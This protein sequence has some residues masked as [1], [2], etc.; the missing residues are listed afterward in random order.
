MRTVPAIVGAAAAGWV[1][2]WAP[3]AHAQDTFFQVPDGVVPAQGE[4]FTQG[5][6][7]IF[8]KVD[9]AAQGVLGLGRGF[10]I[11]LS[12]YNFDFERTKR[13]VRLDRQADLGEDPL[14]PIGLITAQ[15]RFAIA[16]QFEVS[17]G[18]QTGTQIP[19]RTRHL[20]TREYVNAIVPFSK[21]TRCV[22]GGYH[23]NGAFH[24]GPRRFGIWAGCD[25]EIVG[26]RLA[27]EVDFISGTHA[28][29]ATTVGP[30]IMFT[31]DVSVT[32]GV[33]IPNPESEARWAGVAQI[34]IDN[35]LGFF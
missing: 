23:G 28:F 34:E 13:G 24:G 35:F 9:V 15:K 12:L 21:N 6:T 17:F 33:Q 5:Q 29:A 10:E 31:E 14:G 7:S 2:S 11:G 8:S 20:V 26:D 1:A 3:P 18:A 16:K 22:L 25:L 19:G 4:I 30:K 27:I 32:A